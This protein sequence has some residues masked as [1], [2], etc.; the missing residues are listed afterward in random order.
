MLRR[1]CILFLVTGYVLS[2]NKE[3]VMSIITS[4]KWWLSQLTPILYLSK[5]WEQ[6]CW[7]TWQLASNVVGERLI[8]PEIFVQDYPTGLNLAIEEK[9][10]HNWRS[11]PLLLRG[12]WTSE[13][14]SSTSRRLSVKGLL[15][16]DLVI[17]Y[18]KNASRSAELIPDASA[19]IS[20]VVFNISELS[21]PHKIGTQLL[22]L[23]YPDLIYEVAPNKVVTDLFGRFFTPAMV[24]G[25]MNGWLPPITVIPIFMAGS[26]AHNE[27]NCT[28]GE[29]K[30]QPKTDLHCEP[31]ANIFVQLEGEKKITLVGPEYSSLLKPRLSPDGRAYVY[32]AITDGDLTHVPRYEHQ[33]QLGDGLYIP[34]WTW[35]RV[36]YTSGL[37]LS[38]SLFHFRPLDFF[39]RNSLY[40]LVIIPNLILEL[41]GTKSQ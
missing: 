5:Q 23:K 18:F 3:M 33:I 1:L 10:G 7:E 34:S 26:K 12:L 31:I 15:N 2:A 20:D 27:E 25:F 40:A 36:D 22:G 9:Y 24:R 17:P 11:K 41:T 32:S 30:N 4:L 29:L 14:L 38:A 16:E 6:E 19:P 21:M 13:Q 37:A 8:I 35:H 28:E 39:L